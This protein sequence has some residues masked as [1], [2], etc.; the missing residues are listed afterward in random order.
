MATTTGPTT[1]LGGPTVLTKLVDDA[2]HIAMGAFLGLWVPL[3]VLMVP[4]LYREFEQAK[5]A[6]KRR[7]LR[8]LHDEGEQWTWKDHIS[9][10]SFW[11]G[12]IRDVAGFVLGW[13]VVSHQAVY[14]P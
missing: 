9:R 8:R 14:P 11:W 1:S 5:A 2:G 12:K 7:N 10:W 3:W 4:V 6:K 13:V